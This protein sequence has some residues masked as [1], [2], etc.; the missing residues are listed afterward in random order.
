MAKKPGGDIEGLFRSF[1]SDGGSYRELAREA[2]AEE[3]KQRW[4]MLGEIA[5][6]AG[7][8]PEAMDAADK[9]HWRE[10]HDADAQT[11]LPAP[12]ASAEGR[13]LMGGL[14][15][16]LQRGDAPQASPAKAEAPAPKAWGATRPQPAPPPVEPERTPAPPSRPARRGEPQRLELREK[17][18]LFGG[19]ER[20]EKADGATSRKGLSGLFSRLEGE[21]RG[22]KPLTPGR[23]RKR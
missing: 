14:D 13:R 3:A 4:P 7:L 18:G 21:G 9:R 6:E 23:L 19:L 1:G 15:H 20:G 10:R 17:P 2:E 11:A 12:R 8:R 16:L 22:G 5:P